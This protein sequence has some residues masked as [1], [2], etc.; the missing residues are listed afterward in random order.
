MHLHMWVKIMWWG[1]LLRGRSYVHVMTD[2]VDAPFENL[3]QLL[4]SLA[5]TQAKRKGRKMERVF[6]WE[7]AL[8]CVSAYIRLCK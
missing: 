3:Q 5:R 2:D 7:H 8:V 6:M 1:I 4:C